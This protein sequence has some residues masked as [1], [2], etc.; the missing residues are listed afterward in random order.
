M[1]FLQKVRSECLKFI[2]KVSFSNTA[3]DMSEAFP[4]RKDL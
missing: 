2:R 1:V 3:I 4:Q